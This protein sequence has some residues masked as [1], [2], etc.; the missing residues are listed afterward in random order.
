MLAVFGGTGI[1]P[2]GTKGAEAVGAI[3]IVLTVTVL[4]LL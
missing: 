2:N 4:E 3:K 1:E